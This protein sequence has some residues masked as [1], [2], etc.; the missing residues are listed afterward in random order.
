MHTAEKAV[1]IYKYVLIVVCP[2][3]KNVFSC[4][5][6]VVGREIVRLY[7]ERVASIR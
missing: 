6:G 1:K 3:L 4:Y 7:L 5:L 2:N